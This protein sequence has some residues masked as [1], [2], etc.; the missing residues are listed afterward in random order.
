MTRYAGSSS[1]DKVGRWVVSI[2]FGRKAQVKIYTL[3]AFR[4]FSIIFSYAALPSSYVRDLRY[5]DSP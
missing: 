2:S 5:R 4:Q 1:H 3:N